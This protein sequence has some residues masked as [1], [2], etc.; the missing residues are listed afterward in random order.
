M[1]RTKYEPHVIFYLSHNH[2]SM[3]K[4]LISHLKS[5]KTFEQNTT[6]IH[7]FLCCFSLKVQ[8]YYTSYTQKVIEWRY[9]MLEAY[10]M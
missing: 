1:N 2:I 7:Y 10:F 6:S 8:S 3:T 5:I 9:V 4:S